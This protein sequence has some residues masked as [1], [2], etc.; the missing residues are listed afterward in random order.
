MVAKDNNVGHLSV[1][2]DKPI[3]PT[4]KAPISNK[5][6]INR[7]ASLHD[8][9]S[10]I[11]DSSVDLS[12]YTAN[13][14]NKKL[15]SHSS[16]GV[17]AYLCCCIS[18]VLRIFAPNAPYSAQQLSDIFKLFF[19]QF[20]RLTDKKDDP[21]YQQHVYLLKRLAEAKSTILITDLP[22]LEALIV[23]IFNTFYI[24][25]LK[26]FPTELELIITDI[27]SEVLSEA[28]VVPHEVLQLILQ[29][30]SN[31]D[32][33]KLLL[34]N[35]SSPEFNFSL[36]IC[37]YN[38]DRMSRLVAQ[39][40][41]E[42][43]YESTN[44]IEE[45]TD[46]VEDG[47]HT[48]STKSKAN[49]GVSKAIEVLKK[50]HHLSIQLWKFI[51][52]VLSSVMALIDDE[53]NADDDK[54]RTLATVT[55]G[56][57]LAS[58]IY[59]SVSNKVNFFITHKLV[60][61]NWLKK[62]ADVSATVRSKWVQQLP[63]I[64]SS[65]PYLTTEINQIISTCLH[66]CLID[67]DERVR[68][69]ACL[70]INDITYPVFVSKLATPEIMKTLFQLIREKNV[71]IRQTSVQI[72]GSIY[73]KNM[74][75]EDREEISEELQKLIENIPNQLLSLVYINNKNIT[76]LVD[77]CVFE[78]LLEVSESNTSKRVER[79]VRFYKELDERGIEAFVAINKR[80]QQLSKVLLTFIE[81]AESLNKENV[82]DDKENDSSSV[83]KEDVLKLEKIIDWICVSF[84]DGLNTVSCLE[85]FYKLNRIRF[86]HLVKICISPDSD[87]NTIR[88]SMKELLN[89]LND[90]KN[91]RLLDDRSNVTVSEMYENFKLLLL[92][93]SPLIYNRSNV[94][95]LVNYSKDSSN[96]YYS[97]AN[98]LLE[99]I[100]TT[101][102]DV[103]KSHLRSLTNLVVDEHNQITNKS[104]ALKTIYHFV[105][106]YPES[107]PKEV[108]FMNSIRK[109]ATIG[110]SSEAK[111]A[112]KI[113][114]LSDKKEVCCSGIID[115]IYPFNIDDEKFATHLS[116]MA[117]IFVIDNLAILEKENELTP[118][119]I[120]KILLTN[121][122]L[123]RDSEITKEWIGD[124]DIEKYPCLNEK[125]ISIR[126]LV[127]SLRSLDTENSSDDAKEEAKQKALPVVKLLM[128]LIGNNGEI[129]NKKDPSWPTPDVYKLKFRL[130]AGLYM[131]KLAKIP[132]YSETMLLASV[133]RLTFLINNEDY[134]VRSEFIKSLQ[135]K[136]YDKLISEKFLAITFFS[137]L[138]QNQELKNDVT[139]WITSM[140]KRLE[141]KRDMKF[142]KALV[143]LIHTIAHHEQFIEIIKDGNDES[144]L[145]AFNYASRILI[146][147]V[148]L[149][150]TQENVS[151]LYYFASR[152]KQH[153]DATIATSDYEAED[154]SEEI[155]NL[156]RVSE[157]AQLVIKNFADSKNWPMQTWPGKIG[158]P[159][160]IY[161][162]MASSKEA[163]WVV[164]QIF[165]PESQQV[166]LVT[167]IN[168]RLRTASSMKKGVEPSVAVKD[169][170]KR[171]RS[172]NPRR[173]TKKKA[174]IVKEKVSVEPTRRSS[175]ATS[176]VSYKDQLE[177]DSESD[178][179]KEDDNMSDDS[180][181]SDTG[182]LDL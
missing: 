68:E 88:N 85:R 37:E 160:D 104:N 55:I 156:Y 1:K 129:V 144:K 116:A 166:E 134:H 146:F 47:D 36:A 15:L 95:E 93:A 99:Q 38:M 19:K 124:D 137:A 122:D 74:K 9:L 40:F 75:S 79:L 27:L 149:I 10:N 45:E 42:I 113:I 43:L 6:L 168:K 141:S 64:I 53:L 182:K 108:S 159:L 91:I 61:N 118:L 63:G 21:F 119:I 81:T 28:E 51:P 56:Q 107:F 143:R 103:F 11:D 114:G 48:A 121:R 49:H 50:V 7:L 71:V 8:E 33:S 86:F 158:L 84:P 80:Q 35:I 39:Y 14:V 109:L 110:T 94:E 167:L 139:M 174:K 52:T 112:V 165:I 4:V 123:G 30:I 59:P 105:K 13:L 131:L 5:E 170:Q 92:R 12:S 175:R 69:A 82:S 23:N 147:Y 132:I 66:K 148:Q 44:N 171:I 152:V 78:T 83:P 163:Q 77:L 89:K 117:E 169:R 127:N 138:E 135:K 98:A 90:V 76:F 101:I 172:V 173:A 96:E 32:P 150:A 153:R 34:G 57:M 26:G 125:L 31:H 133:R 128:S 164:T 67:T 100:S 62:T 126:L 140:F 72:L 65:N 179:D 120:K 73:S 178:F 29:K 180:D 115:S 41:S 181:Q 60:W 142:E 18:D 58:P 22:D 157:L 70:C 106:K 176:K 102:P 151:L 97:A 20:A 136:L 2:F 16:I 130:T 162:P 154:P 145:A 161:A 24:L 87:F 177:S 25:A 46:I 54:V 3:V 111:Y 17:Q 155:L